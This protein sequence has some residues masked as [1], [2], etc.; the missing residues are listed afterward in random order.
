LEV[1]KIYDIRWTNYSGQESLTI[2]LQATTPNNQVSVKII[3][4][5][6]PA[7]STGNYKWTVTSE[8]PDNKYKIEVYPAGGRELVGRSKDFFTI[9][10]EQL[11]TVKVYFRDFNVNPID[12]CGV[13]VPIT[14]VIP[15]TEKVATAAITELLKGPTSAEKSKGYRT[16]IPSLAR[17]NS[18]AIANG[19]ARADFNSAIE[20]GGS[21]N[22]TPDQIT[23][24]LLQFSTVKTVILS[25]DGRT[26]DIFQP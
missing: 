26:K 4:S 17:L 13:L 16:D 8:S 5:S 7:A 10:S 1:G 11:I 9:S 2:A 15:K 6:V 3:A 12:S 24:T 20:S 18:L 19:E 25:V 22:L 14:R 21:C 23:K